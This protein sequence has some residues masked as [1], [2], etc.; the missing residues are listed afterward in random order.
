MTD[1]AI[2]AEN[3]NYS[4]SLNLSDAS[5]AQAVIDEV[6]KKV[7]FSQWTK[8]TSGNAVTWSLPTRV[9]EVLKEQA[10][11]QALK[12]IDSRINAFGVKEPTL[13]ASRRGF[14]G[15]D[16]SSDAGR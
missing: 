14:F 5:Q 4:V 16:S 6:K 12:I 3:G 8:S 2:V 1:S 11:E 15:T 7:D 9:Q 10:V 13:A